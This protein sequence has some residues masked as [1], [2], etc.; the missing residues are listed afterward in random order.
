MVSSKKHVDKLSYILLAVI[1]TFTVVLF[2]GCGSV[3]INVKESYLL[4]VK[5]S[6]FN[7]SGEVEL[8]LNNENVQIELRKHQKDDRYIEISELLYGM[9]FTMA[10]PDKNGKLKND[11]KFDV[12]TSYDK[13][14]ADELGVELVNTTITC[15][16]K[17]LSEGVE[18]DAFKGLKVEFKGNNGDGYVTVE[19]DDCSKE[20]KKYIFFNVEGSAGNL[21]NGDE[22]TIVANAYVNLEDK[23]YFLKEESKKYTVKGLD[24]ARESLKG[25]DVDSLLS[26]MKHEINEQ[27]NKDYYVCSYDYKFKSGKKR[28]IS[29]YYCSYKTELDLMEYQYVY[30]PEDLET[31]SLIAY[32][33]LTTEF[34]CKSD[35]S[36]ASDDQTPMKKGDKDKGVTYLAVLTTPLLITDDN[37]ISENKYY[38]YSVENCESIED[39]K[40]ELDIDMY[41]SEYYDKDFNVIESDNNKTE[42]VTENSTESSKEKTKEKTTATEPTSKAAESSVEKATTKKAS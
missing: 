22:V 7:G 8:S 19:S 29:S 15:T 31:N 12:I 26:Q 13:E 23:G 30:D 10:D 14:L 17:G 16:A 32:Y 36:Y 1:L 5:M 4:E 25:V 34:K 28:Y 9:K 33:K 27:I 40:D 42:K 20:V 39:L 3:K 38:Y 6:G 35:Q 41:S 21:S 18:I 2:S 11:D 24:G 37:K